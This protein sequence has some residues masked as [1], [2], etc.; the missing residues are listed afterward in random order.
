MQFTDLLLPNREELALENWALENETLS[1][2]ICATRPEAICPHCGTGSHRIHSRYVRTLTDLPWGD[3][4]VQLRWCVRRFFCDNPMCA[5][6]TFAEQLATVAAR[7]ARYTVR[8]YRKIRQVGFDL[9]GQCGHRLLNLFKIRGSRDGVLRL[10]RHTQEE[11]VVTPQVLGLDDWALRKGQIYGT[12]LIDLERH[13]VVDLLPDREPATVAQW[14]QEHPGVEVVAR[15]RGKHYIEGVTQGAPNAIQVADRFHLLGNLR[16]AVQR[17]FERCHAD[18]KAAQAYLA[19]QPTERSSADPVPQCDSE[20]DASISVSSSCSPAPQPT[21]EQKQRPSLRTRRFAR[22]K[23]LQGTG[24]SQREIARRVGLDRRTVKKYLMADTLPQRAFGPQNTSKVL[25]Y[26]DYLAQ[27]WREGVHD[28]TQLWQELREQEFTGSYV[29]VWRATKHLPEYADKSQ[30]AQAPYSRLLSPLQAAWL[31]V[32]PP[33]KLSE[34]QELLCKALCAASSVAATAYVLAQEFG[35]IIRH[36]RADLFDDWLR[37][38]EA[39]G[40]AEFKRLVQSIRGDY[41]AIL[42]ALQMSWSNGQ[43]EGQVNRLKF[44]KRQMYGRAKFDLL[45]LRVLGMPAAA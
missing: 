44:V 21:D 9:G 34:K 4:A 14:L 31:L 45:R 13:C 32:L 16:D 5:K 42:A 43:T 19:Q 8:V 11:A 37:Q 26:S 24:I 40:I 38:A 33:E 1:L 2:Q 27:R 39:S 6:L 29:S 41:A 30:A 23:E 20:E 22:V 3:F 18:L 36:R 35:Q 10:V 12:I 28:V 7:Y 17:I 25:P 15:D